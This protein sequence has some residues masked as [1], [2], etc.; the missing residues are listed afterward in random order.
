MA[1]SFGGVQGRAEERVLAGARARPTTRQGKSGKGTGAGK[2]ACSSPNIH[3][4]GL[5]GAAPAELSSPVSAPR[6]YPTRVCQA[7][8]ALS[9]GGVLLT[10][11][12]FPAGQS[13][14]VP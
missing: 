4:Q 5:A 11:S 7:S 9:A 3:T 10:P 8:S 6:P 14:L 1:T 12:P 13:L 2:T